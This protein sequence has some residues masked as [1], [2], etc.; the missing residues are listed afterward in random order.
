[1][2][3]NVRNVV[4]HLL[5]LGGRETVY[6]SDSDYIIHTSKMRCEGMIR[7]AMIF[8]CIS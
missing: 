4:H 6:S 2:G 3:R 8:L 1:M 7:Y 5:Y